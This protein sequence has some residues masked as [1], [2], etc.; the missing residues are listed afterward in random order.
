PS[1]RFE[2][3]PDTMTF[4]VMQGAP[5]IRD[6]QGVRR[7]S[8]I[9]DLRNMNRLTQ[10]LPGF[11]IAGGFTCEPTDIAVPWRHLHINHSS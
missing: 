6:L 11:H 7:A 5:N 9:E 3:A 10:M 8:T 1:Q 4:G 2:I